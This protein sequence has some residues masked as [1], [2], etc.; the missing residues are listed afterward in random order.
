MKMIPEAED[1]HHVS[2]W[3]LLDVLKKKIESVYIGE[4]EVEKIEEL[5]KIAKEMRNRDE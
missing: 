4:S 2:L 1:Y 3:D 5:L